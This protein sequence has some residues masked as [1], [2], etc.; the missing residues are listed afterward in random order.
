MVRLLSSFAFNFNL[1]RYIVVEDPRVL[2]NVDSL[3]DIVFIKFGGGL[4]RAGKYSEVF[5]RRL[6]TETHQLLGVVGRPMSYTPRHPKYSSRA[7]KYVQRLFTIGQNE[8]R[9]RLERQQRRSVRHLS[10]LSTRRFQAD[11]AV[12][13]CARH[14]I[15]GNPVIY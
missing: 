3:A 6:G 2:D 4:F 1:R 14:E 5:A 11:A 15:L 12:G 9:E 8:R 10:V 13:T 7:W